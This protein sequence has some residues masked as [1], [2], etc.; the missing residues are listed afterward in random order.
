M[1]KKVLIL[2]HSFVRRFEQFVL[3]SLDSR[4]NGNLNLNCDE[5]QIC[6]SGHGGASLER[7][8]A[9]GT[10]YVREQRPDVVILQAVSNDLC[11]PEKT[12]ELIFRRLVEF[13]VDLR[14]GESVKSVVIL[15]TLHRI[16][17][18]KRIRYEVD[19]PWFNSRVDELNRR[20]S[21]YIKEVEGVT[22]FRLS[23][24]W[25]PSTR[26]K[27]YLDDG[28]HLNEQGNIKYF[29]N[30]RAVVVSSLKYLQNDEP[31]WER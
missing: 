6:Y 1:T 30:I 21:D 24:F 12:V 5:V 27:V 19:I 23:G 18:L 22:F 2:G 20:I 8:R 4:V 25:N 11:K 13:V 9:L 17:P 10:S 14:Y 16:A 29:N 28:V 15:Q 7:I 26:S 31:Q 3:N